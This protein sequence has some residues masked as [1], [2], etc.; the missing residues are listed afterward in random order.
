MFSPTNPRGDVT[1]VSPDLTSDGVDDLLD[2][3]S[4]AD[5]VY[6]SYSAG[7]TPEPGALSMLDVGLQ[8]HRADNVFAAG[9]EGHTPEPSFGP[10]GGRESGFGQLPSIV[11]TPEPATVLSQTLGLLGSSGLY[12]PGGGRLSRTALSS[13][14]PSQLGS[15]QQAGEITDVV[16]QITSNLRKL[17]DMIEKNGLPTHNGLQ[18]PTSPSTVHPN[19]PAFS[20]AIPPALSDNGLFLNEVALKNLQNLA[21]IAASGEPDRMLA[22]STNLAANL[23]PST[24]S[25]ESVHSSNASG[26]GPMP[27]PV[28]QGKVNVMQIRCK[29]G[30]LGANKGQFSSPHGFCLGVDEEIVIA[31]TNNHRICIFD[32][33]GEFKSSFGVA[34]KDEGQLWYP[35]KVSVD[36]AAPRDVAASLEQQ[37]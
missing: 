7:T 29:F 12:S 26:G 32:K 10:I 5:S 8:G 19:T 37:N 14:S 31:D 15:Q 36:K 9:S 3:K 33:A 23:Q 21:Q 4:S 2:L 30:Q 25:P 6:G 13:P 16:T 27:F 24:P 28:R 17:A 1:S 22:V 18:S 11:T 35:R 20:A 34:G